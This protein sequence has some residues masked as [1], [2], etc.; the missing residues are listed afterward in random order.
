MH[1]SWSYWSANNANYDALIIEINALST[2]EVAT[3]SGLALAH[4]TNNER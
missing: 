3:S 2:L 1:F 4:R